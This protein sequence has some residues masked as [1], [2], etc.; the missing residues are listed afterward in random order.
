MDWAVVGCGERQDWRD[1]RI[2]GIFK[3]A[4]GKNMEETKKT[5]CKTKHVPVIR[6][7]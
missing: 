3:R 2:Q 6:D 1:R 7:E 4:D 5:I